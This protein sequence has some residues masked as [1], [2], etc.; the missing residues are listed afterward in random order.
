[1]LWAGDGDS[2]VKVID[3]TIDKIVATMSSGGRFRADEMSYD[4]TDNIVLVANDADDPPFGSLISVGNRS[5][6]KEITFTDST[7]GAEQSRYDPL[8]ACSTYRASDQ[9]QSWRR[10]RRH[11]SDRDG[12]DGALPAD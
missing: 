12:G 3:L 5:V 7:N 10:D 6:L 8:T 11:R 4:P 1:V 2:T 9:D